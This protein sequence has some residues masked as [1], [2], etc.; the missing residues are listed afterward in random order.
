MTRTPRTA[1]SLYV[2]VALHAVLLLALA[3]QWSTQSSQKNAV[4]LRLDQPGLHAADRAYLKQWSNQSQ[5]IEESRQLK[6]PEALVSPAA[7]QRRA[8]VETSVASTSK[9]PRRRNA[10]L[11]SEA[12]DAELVPA[13]QILDRAAAQE[14]YLG[15]L[16]SHLAQYRRELPIGLGNAQ[17]M[18]SLELT[19]NGEVRDIY[20]A[21]ASGIALLDQEAIALIL[22][23]A[24]LPKPPVDH[25]GRLQIPISIRE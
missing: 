3:L 22:R 18:V 1:I 16:R 2:A 6:G 14:N 12:A 10:L 15:K 8:V 5:R 23:A 25:V 7:R 17:A 21:R 11:E 19:R 13:P 9:R 20:L 4:G 24:P